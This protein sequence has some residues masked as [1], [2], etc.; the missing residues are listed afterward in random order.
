M[1]ATVCVALG[2]ALSGPSR[3]DAAVPCAASERVGRRLVA[4]TPFAPPCVPGCCAPPA[5]RLGRCTAA[6]ATM[7]PGRS[8]RRTRGQAAGLAF[9]VLGLF[10]SA[11][12]VRRT[13]AR[14]AQTFDIAPMSTHCRRENHCIEGSNAAGCHAF[15][16]CRPRNGGS[17]FFRR[18]CSSS[19]ASRRIPTPCGDLQAV[20][21]P[22]LCKA[23][24]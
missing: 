4:P 22:F 5:Q 20:I 18:R 6:R 19:Q 9:H 7:A 24:R 23:T 13:R 12:T 21:L 16:P 1:Y 17:G 3:S 11:A 2:Q 8:L 10:L 14:C 15:C